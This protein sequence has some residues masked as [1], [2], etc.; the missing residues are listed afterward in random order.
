MP[1]TAR[2]PPRGPWTLRCLA[3]GTSCCS[4][5]LLLVA[6]TSPRWL[7]IDSPDDGDHSGVWWLCSRPVRPGIG[8]ETR[9][10]RALPPPPSPAGAPHSRPAAPCPRGLGS[11]QPCRRPS[12]P[13]RSPLPPG[14]GLPPALPAPLTP[15]PQPPAPGAWAPPSPAGAPHSRP[16]APRQPSPGPLPPTALL[17]PLTPDLQSPQPLSWRRAPPPAVW[18]VRLSPLDSRFP[19]AFVKA[20]RALL[21]FALLASSVAVASLLVSVRPFARWRGSR[22]LVSAT[23]NFIAGLLVLISVVIFTAHVMLDSVNPQAR[24]SFEWAFFL[25]W[26]L[27]PLF[28]LSGILSL[29]VHSCP[30]VLSPRVGPWGQPSQDLGEM[31][32]QG[33]LEGGPGAEPLP[34]GR[35][36]PQRDEPQR[37]AA[38][39]QQSSLGWCQ[40]GAHESVEGKD[41]KG[42][43]TR[44]QGLEEI[45]D[46]EVSC[47]SRPPCWRDG[48]HPQDAGVL[49][50]LCTKPACGNRRQAGD[51]LGAP[52][53][54]LTF[55]AL[56]GFVAVL[57]C[58]SRLACDLLISAAASFTAGVFSLLTHVLYPE[59]G[60]QRCPCPVPGGRSQ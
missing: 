26:T 38:R 5:A 45:E 16:A 3:V 7:L 14:P 34:L 29:F 22:F 56:A 31:L 23:A 32:A 35:A 2:P 37:A 4:L 13:T 36:R 18:M 10:G 27:S 17:V 12:L 49:A 55:A 57:S 53:I 60:P 41:L 6:M 33:E 11:P 50:G 58:C 48:G 30:P 24:A 25:A 15:D 8:T 59:P 46:V 1:R 52:G 19:A 39:G 21:L 40:A 28:V 43:G 51:L 44:R 9:E 47:C 42:M 54:C 20:I